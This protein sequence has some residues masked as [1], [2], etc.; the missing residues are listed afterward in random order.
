MNFIDDKQTLLEMGLYNTATCYSSRRCGNVLFCKHC[1]ETAVSNAI[2]NVEYAE[3][4][5]GE[6]STYQAE[7]YTT[8]DKF[9][10]DQRNMIVMLNEDR[11]LAKVNFGR[12]YP[13]V[14]VQVIFFRGEYVYCRRAIATFGGDT[15][16][17]YLYDKVDSSTLDESLLMLEPRP[18]M[19]GGYKNIWSMTD[20]DTP[21]DYLNTIATITKGLKGVLWSNHD[22]NKFRKRVKRFP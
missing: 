9:Q 3:K 10:Y 1:A 21:L 4:T 5:Y 7:L 14:A 20:D 22:D 18:M 6:T 2:D 12:K 16:D 19:V 13:T 8:I 17:Y 11:R 15:R